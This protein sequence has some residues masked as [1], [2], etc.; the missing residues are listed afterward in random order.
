MQKMRFTQDMVKTMLEYFTVYAVDGVV[1]LERT[2]K[3]VW[4]Q[5]PDGSRQFLGKADLPEH[6]TKKP[7]HMM[8]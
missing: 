1:T 2:E 6:L 8:H 4:L 7:L 5:N 3:G